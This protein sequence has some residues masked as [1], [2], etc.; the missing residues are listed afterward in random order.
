MSLNIV[1]ILFVVTVLLLVFNGLRNGAIFSLINLLSIPVGFAAAQMF[2]GPFTQ[3]LAANG[4]AVTPFIAYVVVFFGAVLILH[5][6]AT[7][8]RGVVQKIPIIGFGDSWVVF[9]MVLGGFL[10]GVHTFTQGVPTVS[11]LT[12]QINQLKAWY[13][14]YNQAVTNSLFAK[15][16]LFLFPALSSFVPSLPHL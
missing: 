14:F 9:L 2:G 8:V 11:G 16:N 6:I 12:I 5:I 4:L 10:G 7:S 1:D 13:D 3:L 15:V